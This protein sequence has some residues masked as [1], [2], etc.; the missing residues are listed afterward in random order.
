LSPLQIQL[1]ALAATLAVEL[2]IAAALAPTRR[3]GAT[4]LAALFANL[5]SHSLAT[6]LL[7]TVLPDWVLVEIGVVAFEA[8]VLR[9]TV[10]MSW[11]RACA[12]SS[13]ANAASA[14]LALAIG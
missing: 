1:L 7:W 10:G 8:V 14:A 5:A 13:I 11:G 3:R 6:V 12:L 4:V 2:P 9:G